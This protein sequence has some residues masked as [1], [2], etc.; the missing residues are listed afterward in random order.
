[1]RHAWHIMGYL[2]PINGLKN[3]VP[4]LV[5]FRTSLLYFLVIFSYICQP[6]VS[7]CCLLPRSS[8]DGLT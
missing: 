4:F 8:M 1:M 7:T 3:V 5:R 2:V 6:I